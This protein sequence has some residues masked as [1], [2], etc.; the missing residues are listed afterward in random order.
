M[1]A[2]GGRVLGEDFAAGVEDGFVTSR[3]DLSEQGFELGE[4]LLDGVEVGGVFRQEDDAGSDIP[5]RPP[6]RL[7]FLG[8][9]IVED[10]D[11]AR[12]Q[13]RHEELF[14]IGVEALAVD[15]PVKQAGRFDAVVAQGGEESRGL[16]FALRDLVD[17][18]LAPWRPATQ[19]RHIG[20][21]PGF[22]DEDQP[23]G[24]GEPLTGSP[25][26]AVATDVRAILLAC[27]KRL[28]LAVTPIRR[29]KR[30]IIE[31]SALTPRSAERR[32]QRA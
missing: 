22:I 6:H 7:S 13:R 8:A 14:D 21:R 25:S 28:F 18:P 1:R 31:V 19:A 12:L 26:F 32:S 3:P 20:L 23:P 16:P 11:V 27:D 9:E 2:F 30:L 4:D 29:K 24:V 15:G 17:E 5:D 10:H